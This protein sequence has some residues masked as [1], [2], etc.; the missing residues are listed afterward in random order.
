MREARLSVVNTRDT[1]LEEIGNVSV[2]MDR[3]CKRIECVS[4]DRPDVILL[5]E[6]FAN[7]FV[8][9][10]PESV[11]QYA[12]TVSGPISE[13]LS[14]LARKYGNYIAF[15]LLRRDGDRFL[16]SLVLLDRS[17]KPVWTYDKVSLFP[18]EYDCGIAPGAMPSPYQ[19]DFGRVGG[20]ICFDINFSELAEIYCRQDVELLLFASAFPAGRLID[21]WATRYGFAIAAST[22]YDRNRIIDCTGAVMGRTSDLVPYTTAV[23]NLNRRVVH[24]DWNMD[25]IDLMRTR[26][27]GDVIIEDLRDEAVCVITSVKKGLEVADLI[28]EFDIERLPDYLDRSRRLRVE[29]G[30]MCV[31]KWF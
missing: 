25:K 16:N 13:E 14:G 27:S 4:R 22:L 20:A 23:L 6:Y 10:T 15:G 17:G 29:A 7:H 26:Y 11:A 12:E 3:A 2:V 19:C 5:T 30:G 1:S 31:P 24:M 18:S 21:F 8:E 9:P 28:K